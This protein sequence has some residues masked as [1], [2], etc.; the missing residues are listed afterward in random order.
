[1]IRPGL[2]ALVL[3]ITACGQEETAAPPQGAGL[4]KSEVVSGTAFL[5]PATR[6][7]QED[8]M[9]NPGYL[10]V[11]EG[12]A[13]F[14]N[15]SGVKAACSSCHGTGGSSLKGAAA[16]YPAMDETSGELVNLEG[17]INLCRT[18]HQD[19]APLAYESE[20]LLSLTA[21]VAN[22][23]HGEPLAVSLNEQTRPYYKAGRDYFYTRRGQLNLSCHQCHDLNWGNQLRGD[24]ISQGHGNGFPAYR[25]EWQTLGSLHRRLRD[26][27]AG[28]RAEPRDYGS[29]EYL[30]LELY[31]A[32]RA[33]GLEIETPAIRR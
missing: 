4:P 26:C 19:A 3:L 5:T 14:E 33:K 28:I 22:L 7:E 13:L 27:E 30:A 1:M 32:I 6:A 11:D 25:L 17:R 24:T 16:R 10:W 18:I 20:A 9:L 15:D 12:E 29:R 21:Y 8:E 23:S 2:L 31:L